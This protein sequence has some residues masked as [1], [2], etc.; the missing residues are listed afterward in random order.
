MEIWRNMRPTLNLSPSLSSPSAA[1]LSQLLSTLHRLPIYRCTDCLWGARIF[2]SS[3]AALLQNLKL[4]T[5]S[6]FSLHCRVKEGFHS[7]CAKIKWLFIISFNF[8]A[9]LSLPSPCSA[10][11]GSLFLF[12]KSLFIPTVAKLRFF[13][14]SLS[15]VAQS[16]KSLS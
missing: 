16:W 3:F 4:S 9:L 14:I 6:D 11:I 12:F 1:L 7:L 15:A 2:L 8:F 10:D 5:V 13:L